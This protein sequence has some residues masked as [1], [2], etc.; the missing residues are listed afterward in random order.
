M[1]R[2]THMYHDIV[3]FRKHLGLGWRKVTLTLF[4]YTALHIMQG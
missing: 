2:R 1:K 4:L 3:V